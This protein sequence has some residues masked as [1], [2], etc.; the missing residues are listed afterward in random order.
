MLI[1]EAGTRTDREDPNIPLHSHSY[2]C[3]GIQGELLAHMTEIYWQ[4]E[5]TIFIC[6]QVSSLIYP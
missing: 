2:V 3:K 6:M 5:A 4:W 1:A